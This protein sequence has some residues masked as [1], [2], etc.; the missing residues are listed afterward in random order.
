MARN[1]RRLFDPKKNFV[2][3]RELTAGGREFGSD[4]PFDKSLVSKRTLRQMWEQRKIVALP[5]S[6]S[7]GT[8]AIDAKNLAADSQKRQR[9]ERV[10]LRT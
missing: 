8:P 9:V 4:A 6:I 5:E 1:V 10:R 3:T 2:T 7:G